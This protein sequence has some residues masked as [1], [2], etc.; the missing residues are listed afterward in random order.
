MAFYL[1]P[2]PNA[3]NMHRL[4]IE[5]LNPEPIHRKNFIRENVRYVKQMQ[6]LVQATNTPKYNEM[7]R[8]SG[9]R[10]GFYHGNVKESTSYQQTNKKQDSGMAKQASVN[11][12]KF[13][14][15]FSFSEKFYYKS[16]NFI[17]K[18]SFII[19]VKIVL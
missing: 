1:T 13:L 8:P 5:P 11:R 17:M 19:K 16:K 12:G 18:E 2:F 3:S 10:N 15:T 7:N 4:H 9:M 14:L 6:G